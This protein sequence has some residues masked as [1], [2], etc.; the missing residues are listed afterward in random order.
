MD[1]ARRRGWRH[2]ELRGA[3]APA[4]TRAATMFHGHHLDLDPADECPAAAAPAVHRAV[5]QAIRAGVTVEFGAGEYLLRRFHA[6][7]VRTRRRHGSPPAPWR[8][9]AALHSA[10]LAG[11]HGFVAVAVRGGKDLASAVFLLSGAQATYKYG[12]S[13]PENHHLRPNHLV[14]ARAAA[15]CARSGCTRLDLG[16]TSLGAAGLRRY[17]LSWGA[18]ERPIAYTRLDAA[19]GRALRA[20]DHA[21]GRAAAVL[22]FLPSPFLRALGAALHPHLA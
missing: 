9:F 2:W 8:F 17:K 12:A 16:R 5:R 3:G 15:R 21:G 1:H 10:V 22:R 18:T 4:G 20:P 14:M 7:Y 6:L 19:T 11:G 13:D